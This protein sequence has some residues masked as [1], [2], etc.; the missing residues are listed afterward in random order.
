MPG[1][2][3]YLDGETQAGTFWA[4]D[5]SNDP[6]ADHLTSQNQHKK[7]GHLGIYVLVPMLPG[8]YPCVLSG[9][10]FQLLPQEVVS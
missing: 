2:Y 10:L 9:K 1:N 6:D 4:G 8:R 7:N 5:N 3:S